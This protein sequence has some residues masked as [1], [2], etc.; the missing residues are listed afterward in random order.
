MNSAGF[1][2]RRSLLST[3]TVGHSPS[4]FLRLLFIFLSHVIDEGFWHE[5]EC[6]HLR[7]ASEYNGP[8]LVF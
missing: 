8:L 6:G 4:P 7:L 5:V 2:N 1:V 3:V